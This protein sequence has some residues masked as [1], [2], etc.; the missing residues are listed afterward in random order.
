MIAFEYKVMFKKN[1]NLFLSKVLQ[2]SKKQT[3]K[4]NAVTIVIH[5][6]LGKV[7]D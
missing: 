6:T 4:C 2:C 3:K 1:N 7:A 5:F